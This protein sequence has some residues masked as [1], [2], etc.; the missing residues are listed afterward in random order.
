[1]KSAYDFITFRNS[2][3]TTVSFQMFAFIV[4]TIE[5]QHDTKWPVSN[6]ELPVDC[7]P[8]EQN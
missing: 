8:I 4:M 1:M 7:T 6:V 2:N 3:E 5:A